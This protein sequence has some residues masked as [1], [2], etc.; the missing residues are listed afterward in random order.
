MND[1]EI[2]LLVAQYGL[3]GEA[4]DIAFRLSQEVERRT[5]HRYH[6]IIALVN[7]AADRKEVE[8]MPLDLFLFNHRANL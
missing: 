4:G 7:T 6:A 5:R 8:P 1:E 2:K 3:A